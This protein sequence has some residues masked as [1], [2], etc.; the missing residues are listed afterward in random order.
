MT[1]LCPNCGHARRASEAVPEWQCPSCG[2]AYNKGAGALSD[3][4]S[5]KVKHDRKRG[6]WLIVGL[7]IASTAWAGRALLNETVR[8]PSEAAASQTEPP[9]IYLYSTQWCGY[10]AAARSFMDQRG[11]RYTERDIEKSTAAY[12]DYRRLG[13][14]GVTAVFE[15]HRHSFGQGY[16]IF[17]P[18][19]P[20]FLAPEDPREPP[21]L[22]GFP[23]DPR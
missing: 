4:A 5:L 18:A 1:R 21:A 14:R 16:G 6:R 20:V 13:G 15:A 23:G 22:T 19:A 9:A 2:K 17:R 7:V 12:D 3:V 11:I 10:C 8:I